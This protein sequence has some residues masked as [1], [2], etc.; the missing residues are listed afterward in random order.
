MKAKSVLILKICG[1]K[2][3]PSISGPLTRCMID[4]SSLQL[5][6]VPLFC[7]DYLTVNGSA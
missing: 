4:Y 6:V 3:E 2:N 5:G 1:G 7:F